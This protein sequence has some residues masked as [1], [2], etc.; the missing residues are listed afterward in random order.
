MIKRPTLIILSVFILSIG[1]YLYLDKNPI[2]PQDKSVTPTVSLVLFSDL[3][4]EDISSIKYFDNQQ[5]SIHIELGKDNQWF[6]ASENNIGIEWAIAEDLI[7]TITGIR[8][9]ST[10]S[11]NSAEEVL[12][13]TGTSKKIE[14]YKKNGNK[15]TLVIGNQTPTSSGYYVKRLEDNTIFIVDRFTIETLQDKLT[16]SSLTGTPEPQPTQIPTIPAT[17]SP[18]P[19]S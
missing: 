15:F 11:T 13:I 6:L 16:K 19:G 7:S 3:K 17:P 5:P 4:F 14:I 2:K 9:Q 1:A 12:G 10:I 8:I 18:Q